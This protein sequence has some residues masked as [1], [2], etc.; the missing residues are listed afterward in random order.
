VRTVRVTVLLTEREHTT[1]LRACGGRGVATLLVRG[2]LREAG[3]LTA[4]ASLQ[5]I[6]CGDVIT[7]ST[8]NAEG[9]ELRKDGWVCG[10]CIDTT[11]PTA[12][13]AARLLDGATPE[14]LA[15]LAGVGE[16]LTVTSGQR[17]G[18]TKAVKR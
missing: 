12:G 9:C 6:D 13:L 15:W 11:R 3:P 8:M 18:K 1:L 17:V 7:P 14:R 16:A 2:G 10:T 5:C 4:S